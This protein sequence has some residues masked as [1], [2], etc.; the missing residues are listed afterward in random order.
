MVRACKACDDPDLG[1]LAV[2]AN[3]LESVGSSPL[4]LI[5]NIIKM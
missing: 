2:V 4:M 3:G 5:S 1:R